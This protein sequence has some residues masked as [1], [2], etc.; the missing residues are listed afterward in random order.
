MIEI[1]R[2]RDC[3]LE[4]LREFGIAE[5]AFIEKREKLIRA[6]SG[7]ICHSSV[8]DIEKKEMMELQAKLIAGKGP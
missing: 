3:F 8:S 2:F 6:C 7:L 4:Y 5:R 1:E